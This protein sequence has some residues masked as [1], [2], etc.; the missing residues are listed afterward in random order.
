MVSRYTSWPGNVSFNCAMCSCIAQDW[1][2]RK[3]EGWWLYEVA[4]DLSSLHTIYTSFAL[5][6]DYSSSLQQTCVP[7]KLLPSFVNQKS[8]KIPHEIIKV[9]TFPFTIFC[10][11]W[12]WNNLDFK[13]FVHQGTITASLGLQFCHI[14]KVTSYVTTYQ[15]FGSYFREMNLMKHFWNIFWKGH[16]RSRNQLLTLRNSKNLVKTLYPR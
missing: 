6:I 4:S 9:Y 16:I 8:L 5:K 1:H 12:L 15:Q 11:L 2:L 7:M 14:S 13:M 3:S 10:L